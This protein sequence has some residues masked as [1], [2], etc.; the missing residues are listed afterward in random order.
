MSSPGVS[1]PG[2]GCGLIFDV[3]ETGSP[4]SPGVPIPG[5]TFGLMSAKSKQCLFRVL[6]SQI[7]GTSCG[8]IPSVIGTG[9][10]SNPGVSVPSSGCVLIPVMIVN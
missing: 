6:E 5:N 1:I 8:L 3:I 4:S 7:G 2:T 10:V 9:S